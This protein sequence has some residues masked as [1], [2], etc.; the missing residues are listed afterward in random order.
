M[1]DNLYT[2]NTNGNWTTCYISSDAIYNC[3]R[4]DDGLKK[5]IEELKS[6]NT[7]LK[8]EIKKFKKCLAYLNTRVNNLI[9]EKQLNNEENV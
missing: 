7:F 8:D 4:L 9:A 3:G 1:G 6:E 5:E 2:I